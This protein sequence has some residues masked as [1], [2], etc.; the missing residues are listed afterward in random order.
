M[1]ISP[2]SLIKTFGLKLV[3]GR[4]FLP[5]EVTTIDNDTAPEDLFP[6]S[7]IVT[8]ALAEKVWPGATS[9]VGKTL[10]FGTGEK[11]NGARVVGVLEQLQTQSAQLTDRGG[12]SSIVPIRLTNGY[13]TL[14][15]MRVEPG[16][17]E[18]VIKPI[19]RCAILRHFRHRQDESG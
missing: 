3:E 1:Y 11:A 2:D 13:S 7:V 16:Q 17:R 12:Y 14:Y 15:A 5:E 10:Y 9:F 19:W 4:D 8:R 6:P 18:R